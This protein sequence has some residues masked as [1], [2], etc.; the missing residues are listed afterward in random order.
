MTSGLSIYLPTLSNELY[1][2]LRCGHFCNYINPHYNGLCRRNNGHQIPIY[3]LHLSQKLWKQCLNTQRRISNQDNDTA[4]GSGV[5]L[6]FQVT[7]Y[8]LFITS[9]HDLY[10][11]CWHRSTWIRSVAKI[12]KS[13]P[14]DIFSTH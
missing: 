9:T 1:K 13:L 2:T 3:L 12:F 8:L 5:Y 6:S 4:Y 14:A 7:F 10:C 11:S